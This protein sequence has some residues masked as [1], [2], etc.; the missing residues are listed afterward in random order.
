[1]SKMK[2]DVLLSN[3]QKTVTGYNTKMKKDVLLSNDQK[4]VT[5]YNTKMKKDVLLSNDQKTV[6]GYKHGDTL[7]SINCFILNTVNTDG[8]CQHC[9]VFRSNLFARRSHT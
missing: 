6:T 7:R 4:T 3:D 2:K 9:E 1:M 5:G 8:S